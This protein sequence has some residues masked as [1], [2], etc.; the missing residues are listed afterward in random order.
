MEMD[1]PDGRRVGLAGHAR[2]HFMRSPDAGIVK[3]EVFAAPLRP[4]LDL[5]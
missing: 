5:A 1:T 2:Y 3:H 4:M